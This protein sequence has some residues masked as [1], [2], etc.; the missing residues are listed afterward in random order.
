MFEATGRQRDRASRVGLIL[1]RS[2]ERV[3]FIDSEHC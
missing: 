2:V 3:A 1:R